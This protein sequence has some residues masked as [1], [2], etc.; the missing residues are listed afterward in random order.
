MPPICWHLVT[1]QEAAQRLAVPCI[2]ACPAWFLLG[3][4]AP[5]SRVISPLTRAQTHFYDL[6]AQE[7]ESGTVRIFQQY[8][9]LRGAEL[10]DDRQR[11]F[12]AGYLTHL[13]VDELWIESVYRPVFGGASPLAEDAQRNLLDRI[14]QFGMDRRERLDRERMAAIKRTVQ[15]FAPDGAIGFLDEP[16]LRRWQEVICTLTDQIPDWDVFG[17]FAGRYYPAEQKDEV[18]RRAP[19][20]F[21]RA[22]AHAGPERLAAFRAE[23]IARSVQIV[24]GY[25]S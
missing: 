22:Q 4:T 12:V 14:V 11:A 20:L 5:D 23:A 17:R 21:E 1:M 25:L 7:Q 13:V 3:A 15:Q 10:S 18:V 8:P 16:L 2:D 19:E 6:E 9:E 24:R